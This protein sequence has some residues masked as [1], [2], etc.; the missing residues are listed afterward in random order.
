MIGSI[1]VKDTNKFVEMEEASVKTKTD[2]EY[3]P[4]AL[5]LTLSPIFKRKLLECNNN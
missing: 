1:E 4:S 5:L 2:D 3:T